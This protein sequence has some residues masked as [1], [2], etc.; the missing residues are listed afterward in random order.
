V[1]HGCGVGG[2]TVARVNPS[3][4][5]EELERETGCLLGRGLSGRPGG[6]CGDDEQVLQPRTH[7]PPGPRPRMGINTTVL[8]PC[9]MARVQCTRCGANA[10]GAVWVQLVYQATT[11]YYH[12]TELIP[13]LLPGVQRS[14]QCSRGGADKPPRHPPHTHPEREFLR[15]LSLSCLVLDLGSWILDV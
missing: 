15:S 7:R 12:Q 2:S 11:T 4:I 8:L 6:Q 10:T 13:S 3:H 14:A 5:V 1:L 9:V